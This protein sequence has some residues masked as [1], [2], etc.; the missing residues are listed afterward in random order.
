MNLRVLTLESQP[1]VIFVGSLEDYERIDD[2]REV[3]KAFVSHHA[4]YKNIIVFRES[5][6]H[7]VAC[8]QS[9]RLIGFGPSYV[10]SVSEGTVELRNR[11]NDLVAFNHECDSL[12]DAFFLGKDL[13]LVEELSIIRIHADTLEITQAHYNDIIARAWVDHDE[14][15]VQMYDEI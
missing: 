14:L 9:T 11:T 2:W 10:A 13:I 1:M 3:K 15:K 4:D 12:N 6:I 5:E 7:Y 8:Q